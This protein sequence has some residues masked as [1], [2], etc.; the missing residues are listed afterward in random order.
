MELAVHG[1][2][3]NVG[4]SLRGHVKDKLE[5]LS[6]KYFNHT[7]YASVTFSRDGHG[8]QQTKAHITIQLGKNI[9][10]MADAIE[11][12]PYVAFDAAAAKAGKQLR[13]YK[14]RLRDHHSR[15]EQTPESE[16]LKARDYVLASEQDTEGEA[17]ESSGD[18]VVIADM[19]TSIQSMSVSEAVMRMDLSGQPALLFRNASHGGLNM[20][21]RRSDGH[22]GWVDPE[23][24]KCASVEKPS[25][26]SKK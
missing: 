20:I 6:T 15:I 14:R 21:Y 18:P 22:V 5:D 19:A 10:V 24:E 12:D 11:T 25:A 26:K 23:N 7:T 13:R 17:P 1:K 8:H 2:Q 4:E 3:M 9:M 16:I